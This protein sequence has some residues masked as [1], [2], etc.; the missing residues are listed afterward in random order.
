MKGK[1]AWTQPLKLLFPTAAPPGIAAMSLLGCACGLAAGLAISLLHGLIDLAQDLFREIG[2][3]HAAFLAPLAGAVLLGLFY[4][5]LKPRHRTTG[6][7]HIV[8]RVLHHQGHLPS[9][10]AFTNLFGTVIAVGSGQMVGREGAAS[11]LGAA[12]GSII[13]RYLELPNS[14]VRA[15][16]GCGAAAGIAASFNTPLAGVI[17]TMEVIVMEYSVMGL[18][19][20]ILAAV[21]AN[22][23]AHVWVGSHPTLT[24]SSTEIESL[25]QLPYLLVL[26]A[27][28]GLM[29]AWYS[30][31]IAWLTGQMGRL[32]IALSMSLAG[33]ATALVGLALP[34]VF[35][36]GFDNMNLALTGQLPPQASMW[37]GLAVLAGSSLAIA[38]AMPGG[39][40]MPSMLAG[41][42]LG[43]AFGH[44]GHAWLGLPVEAISLFALLGLGAMM[45]A[46][47]Q[48]PLTALIVVLELSGH[49]EMLFAAML[50]VI[51]AVMVNR[52]VSGAESI[53][54]MLL[55]NRGLDFRNDPVS[56][57][58]RRISVMAAM[59]R[60]FAHADEEL[61][62]AAARELLQARPDWLL[63]RPEGATP[64]VLS[65]ADTQHALSAAEAADKPEEA[66][67][68]LAKIPGDRRQCAPVHLRAS[69]QEAWEALQSSGAEAL[70][71][72][73]QTRHD[74]RVIYGILTRSALEKAYRPI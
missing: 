8:E 39:I 74:Q 32:P 10:N 20:T 71:V 51:L 44:W 49:T 31:S 69:L 5:L 55:R 48:A 66:T 3:S 17:F 22:A 24:V 29:S 7:V 50:T 4:Q 11:H 34:L 6:L 36:D 43:S 41:A 62:L 23:V 30:H 56:Q 1:A 14:T 68:N 19:P 21:S 15:L 70:Y 45:G 73:R 18:A 12:S 58:L 57:S 63:V 35:A 26:G 47:L 64:Y 38:S 59:S 65:A 52:Q 28:L 42:C 67:I 60:N 40:I 37:L 13:G 16:V 27:G 46:V 25:G 33:L 61:S 54:A 53:V 72:E 9:R 2:D